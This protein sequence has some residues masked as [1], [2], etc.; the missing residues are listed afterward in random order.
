MR[1]NGV[2]MDR[3]YCAKDQAQEESRGYTR[4]KGDNTKRLRTTICL[5][6]CKRGR[7]KFH[8]IFN[9]LRAQPFSIDQD[10]GSQVTYEPRRLRRVRLLFPAKRGYVC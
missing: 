9:T 5:T 6:T 10:I 4:E 8:L 3:I 7:C 2:K 1:L